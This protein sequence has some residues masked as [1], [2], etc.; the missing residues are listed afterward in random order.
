MP[1]IFL[2]DIHKNVLSIENADNEQ[3]NAFKQLSNI[4]K[5]E[6]SIE[7]FPFLENGRVLLK[8]RESVL[9]SFKS[10]AF[11]IEN[12]TPKSTPNTTLDLTVFYISKKQK[13][14]VGY[15]KL[16]YFHLD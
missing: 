16:K 8:S 2:K 14:L 7:N 13:H 4:S 10:N 1:I 12:I 6:I 5:G 15:L 3:S 9:N 11:A